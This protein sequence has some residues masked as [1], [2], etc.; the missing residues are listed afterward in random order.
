M[1]VNGKERTGIQGTYMCVV[2][3]GRCHTTGASARALSRLNSTSEAKLRTFG[4][5][6]EEEVME[7]GKVR[8]QRSHLHLLPRFPQTVA[9][10]TSTLVSLLAHHCPRQLPPVP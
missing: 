9:I 10:N 6:G 5:E 2:G 1:L 8:L 3:A 7:R 4:Q